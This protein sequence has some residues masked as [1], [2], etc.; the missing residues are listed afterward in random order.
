M[1]A[2]KPR[3]DDLIGIPY[4]KC[5]LDPKV[6]VDCL[7]AAR[8]VLERIYPGLDPLELPL[9]GYEIEEA[10]RVG[11]L[12]DK[13]WNRVRWCSMLGDLVFCNDGE[14]SASVMDDPIGRTVITARVGR[15]VVRMPFR[16]LTNIES[17]WRRKAAPWA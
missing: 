10:V 6:G 17:V 11:G 16:S 8:R 15:G 9:T 4:L 3:F 1:I 14:P 7:W 2:T 13:R 5:G 12:L